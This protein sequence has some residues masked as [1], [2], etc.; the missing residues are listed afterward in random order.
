[1]KRVIAIIV[2]L[3]F[4]CSSFAYAETCQRDIGGNHPCGYP[5][6]WCSGEYSVQTV[7]THTYTPGGSTGV[8]GITLV[9]SY[10]WRTLYKHYECS[11]P[12]MT[13][14]NDMKTF[15]QESGHSCGKPWN[16]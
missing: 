3:C 10:V 8:G 15:R 9:C 13:H 6:S 5:M 1:M 2:V 11:N 7:S 12:R 4:A 14:V 16:Y